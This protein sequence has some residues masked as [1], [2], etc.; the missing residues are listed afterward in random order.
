MVLPVSIQLV[1]HN[2]TF[3]TAECNISMNSF[4]QKK[5]Q[6]HQI[7]AEEKEENSQKRED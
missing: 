5:I 3:D 7:T 2:Y 1:K 4:S 6:H